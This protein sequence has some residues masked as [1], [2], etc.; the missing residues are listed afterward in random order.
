MHILS[1]ALCPNCIQWSLCQKNSGCGWDSGSS[2]SRIGSV[3]SD[4]HTKTVSPLQ[5]LVQWICWVKLL[6]HEFSSTSLHLHGMVLRHSGTVIHSNYFYSLSTSNFSWHRYGIFYLE[7]LG[8]HIFWIKGSSIIWNTLPKWY[9]DTYKSLVGNEL[10]C[11]Q[12]EGVVGYLR[13]ITS[14][15]LRR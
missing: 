6:K 8:L 9:Y 1:T 5:P 15:Q 10:F 13:S 11:L 7:Y 2:V 3:F 14:H 4:H 12:N